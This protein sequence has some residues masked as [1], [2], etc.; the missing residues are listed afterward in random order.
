MLQPPVS[1]GGNFVNSLNLCLDQAFHLKAMQYRDLLAE[2]LGSDCGEVDLRERAGSNHHFS[3]TKSPRATRRLLG[4]NWFDFQNGR[5]WTGSYLCRCPTTIN[6][7][8]IFCVGPR[9]SHESWSI[10]MLWLSCHMPRLRAALTF[11]RWTKVPRQTIR[12]H[13]LSITAASDDYCDTSWLMMIHWWCQKPGWSSFLRSFGQAAACIP[14]STAHISQLF[15]KFLW[16]KFWYFF[17]LIYT[18]WWI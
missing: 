3:S 11:E 1:H 12:L 15:F 9:L 4:G 7:H 18:I 8:T 2:F 10:F 16:F 6:F 13:S 14:G 17:S 5:C